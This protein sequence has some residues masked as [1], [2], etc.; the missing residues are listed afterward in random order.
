MLT[1]KQIL[2]HWSW[3]VWLGGHNVARDKFLRSGYLKRQCDTDGQVID[4]RV[5]EVSYATAIPSLE[6]LKTR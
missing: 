4:D 2:V 1:I 6:P 3:C 5:Q